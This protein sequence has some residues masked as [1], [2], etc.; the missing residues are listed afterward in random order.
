MFIRVAFVRGRRLK[1]GIRYPKKYPHLTKHQTI[2]FCS[3]V[4]ILEKLQRIIS[5]KVV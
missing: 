2:A 4:K 3:T 5:M 1:E